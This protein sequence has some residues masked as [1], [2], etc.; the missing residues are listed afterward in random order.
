VDASTIEKIQQLVEA[1]RTKEVSGGE[2]PDFLVSGTSVV[3][4]EAHQPHRMFPRGK[5]ACVSVGALANY[6]KFRVTEQPPNLFIDPLQMSAQAIFDGFD[7]RTQG[8][9]KDIAVCKLEKTAGF[10]ALCAMHGKRFGQK[11]FIDLLTDWATCISESKSAIAAV[12]DVKVT[13]KTETG[14]NVQQVST[15]R[16]LME[17]A[18][19]S[20]TGANKL[21]ESMVFSV[22][23][24]LGFGVYHFTV[25]IQTSTDSELQFALRVDQYESILETLSDQFSVFLESKTGIKPLL[26]TFT[27]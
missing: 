23:P 2:L 14:S 12:R 5:F 20:S 13:V 18:E 27:P 21:P 9:C 7:H 8:H 25:G 24:Y 15:K 11:G 6:L 4:T 16:S 1:A 22:E 17:E 19:A 3:S 10:A 26:G